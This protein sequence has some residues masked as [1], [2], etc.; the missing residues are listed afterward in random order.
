VLDKLASLACMDTMHAGIHR[1]WWEVWLVRPPVLV[2]RR[3]FKSL[4]GKASAILLTEQ[5][6]CKL[7]L[8]ISIQN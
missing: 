5:Y 1:G 7:G 6:S 8:G 3:W 2:S 4:Y